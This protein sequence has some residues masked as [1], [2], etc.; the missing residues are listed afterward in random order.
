[1]MAGVDTLFVEIQMEGLDHFVVSGW[2][3]LAG[4]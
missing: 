1:M 2:G 4:E 3:G